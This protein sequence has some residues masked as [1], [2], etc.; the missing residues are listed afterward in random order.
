MQEKDFAHDL[1]LQEEKIKSIE[2]LEE[3]EDVYCLAAEINGTMIANGVVVSNCDALRYAIASHKVPKLYATGK[4][5][6]R[7]LGYK[8]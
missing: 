5:F 3:E 4:D 7:T 2:W 1:V 8:R 6:G